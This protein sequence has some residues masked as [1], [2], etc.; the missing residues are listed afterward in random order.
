[1][2]MDDDERYKN[3]FE[4]FKDKG[5]KL[6]TT[7]EELAEMPKDKIPKVK[8]IALCGHEH[9]VHTN[10]FF[11]RGTGL[12]CPACVAK[13][14]GKKRSGDVG[15]TADGQSNSH[16]IEDQAIEYLTSILSQNFEAQRVIDGCL[17][18]MVIKLDD[19]DED[20]WLQVQVKSTIQ[21]Y[22][23]YSFHIKKKYNDCI[24]ICVCLSDKKMWVFDGNKI[25][26]TK[27]SIGL[28][29]SKYDDNEV[30]KETIKT[31]LQ[32]Y[33]YI[34]TF[35][36]D[37]INTPIAETQK[38]E[39]RFRQLR[40][41][42]CSFITFEYPLQTG[43]CY[44]FLTNGKRFQEKV[45]G[46]Q[47]NKTAVNYCVSKNNGRVEGVRK[48]KCYDKGENDFYWLHHPNEN[49]FFIVPDNVFQDFSG[50]KS[51]A[52]NII[53]AKWKDYLFSYDNIENEKKKIMKLIKTAPSDIEI[54]RHFNTLSI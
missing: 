50:H 49:D 41:A 25:D 23:T 29:T 32:S 33:K 15:K 45:G 7:M 22:G 16:A 5:C 1:M 12:N 20:S 47:N 21:P 39:K 44:D 36:F 24:I 34:P 2:A 31:I 11:S 27:I 9:T 30:T 53:K 6:L 14:S 26:V 35:P 4:K 54:E 48:F 51:L 8:Y 40:E 43:L 18:D 3:M 46:V 13:E 17:A 19:S 38:L 28:K 10:V 42:K 52:H 37:F